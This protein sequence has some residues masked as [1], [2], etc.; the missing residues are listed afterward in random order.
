MVLLELGH[1]TSLDKEIARKETSST[2]N[3]KHYGSPDIVDIEDI[4]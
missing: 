4:R 3:Y 2:I 1:L